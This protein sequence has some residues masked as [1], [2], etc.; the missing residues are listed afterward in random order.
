MYNKRGYIIILSSF[1]II[2]IVISYIFQAIYVYNNEIKRERFKLIVKESQSIMNIICSQLLYI[3]NK[4]NKSIVE[5]ADI[6]VNKF[7][8]K[9]LNFSITYEIINDTSIKIYVFSVSDGIMM[10]RAFS[11]TT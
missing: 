4:E 2:C 5:V 10:S 6:I 8:I 3:I 1:I 9:L 7:N 11:S